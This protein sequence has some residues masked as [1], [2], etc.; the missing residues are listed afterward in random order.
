MKQSTIA[1]QES[2]ALW[3]PAGKFYPVLGRQWT[4]SK[5]LS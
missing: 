5:P 4:P 1:A 2:V 3:K